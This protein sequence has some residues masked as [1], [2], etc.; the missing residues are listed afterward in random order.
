[1]LCAAGCACCCLSRLSAFGSIKIELDGICVCLL[2]G[3]DMVAG[4]VDSVFSGVCVDIDGCRFDDSRPLISGLEGITG[5][6][7]GFIPLFIGRDGKN[8]A[9]MIVL[10]RML[11]D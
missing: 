5:W 9:R 1:M 4:G 2:T 11:E 7:V 8:G 10:G 6:A 3:D